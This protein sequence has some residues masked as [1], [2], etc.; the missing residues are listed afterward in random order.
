MNPG[1]VA[2]FHSAQ[3]RLLQSTYHRAWR[4]GVATYQ[5]DPDPTEKER[6]R[7]RERAV[8]ASIA[9]AAVLVARGRDYVPPDSPDP[10]AEARAMTGARSSLDRMAGELMALTPASQHVE[11]AAEAAAAGE[12]EHRD[13]ASYAEGLAASDWAD[14]NAWRLNAGDSVAWAGEQAGYSQAAAADGQLLE[15]LPEGDERV[16]SDCEQLGSLPPMPMD[17]WPTQPGAGDT[18]CNAGCR[19]VLQVADGQELLGAGDELPALTQDENDFISELAERREPYAEGPVT[20]PTGPF[21][22]DIPLGR[23]AQEIDQP[24]VRQVFKDHDALYAQAEVV[25]PEFDRILGDAGARIGASVK[26]FEEA[27]RSDDPAAVVAPLKNG[28]PGGRAFEKVEGNYKGDWSRLKD[29]VRGTIVVPAEEDLL[30][31]LNAIEAA[32]RANPGWRIVGVENRYS[33]EVGSLVNTG[34]NGF[35]YRDVSMH[36]VSPEG[37]VAEVQ[38]NTTAMMRAKELEGGHKLYEE[39]RSILP[40]DKATWTSD[41]ARLVHIRTRE[42]QEL[43]HDAERRAQS[44]VPLP[45]RA[46]AEQ[47]VAAV[48]NM[49]SEEAAAAF[50]DGKIADT[51]TRYS[52]GGKMTRS[53][54]LLHKELIANQVLA[55]KPA[56]LREAMFTAGG[57]ASGKGSLLHMAGAP[58]DAVVVDPDKIRELL[59]EYQAIKDLGRA[60]IAAAATH[61]EASQIAK[62]LTQVATATRRN[63]IVDGVGD[64]APGKFAGKIQAAVDAGY[65]TQVRYMHVSTDEAL[66]RAIERFE[67]TGRAVPEEELRSKHA[68]V[69]ARYQEV[70][71]LHGVHRVN[72][73]DNGGPKGSEPKLVSSRGSDGKLDV[74]DE[75]IQRE[76]EEKVRELLD[77]G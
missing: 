30:D 54:E 56:E 38:L 67:R 59:P 70:L 15:W 39:V 16:C 6:E 11:Q 20:R 24:D 72:L 46:Q 41:E 60:D 48:K 57:P 12:I 68:E 5:P 50:R 58:P 29:V 19:C 26:P 37:H 28:A 3:T 23:R 40:R 42:S 35:G 14:S 13:I 27:L 69:S 22:G 8:T 25:K 7:A 44:R 51:L 43:Y 34:A 10:D 75:E 66:K 63:L 61:E 17:D 55:H 49:S 74:Y 65:K 45:P 71:K 53:R 62:E 64:S 52:P 32:V 36:L 21:V 77:E 4:H 73:Y 33:S 31:G 2:R 1:A 76:F 18:I 47:I 9:A